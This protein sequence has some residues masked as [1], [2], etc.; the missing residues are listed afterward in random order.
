M[1]GIDGSALVGALGR[2]I[3]GFVQ[4]DPA[5]GDIVEANT[6]AVLKD[7]S[8][9]CVGD[10]ILRYAFA[11]S[12]QWTTGGKVLAAVIAAEPETQAVL[13]SQRIASSSPRSRCG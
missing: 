13:D 11:S 9:M 6:S 2:S 7:L 5:P 12:T 10:A 4:S 3:N 1:K 8:T